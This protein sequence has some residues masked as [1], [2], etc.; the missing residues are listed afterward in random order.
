VT[1][2]PTEVRIALFVTPLGDHRVHDVGK[3]TASVL[4]RLGQEV[5]ARYPAPINI[6]VSAG[7]LRRH[8]ELASQSEPASI[9]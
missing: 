6:T 5:A 7:E 1:D 2:G 8:M 4:A 3:A 9:S